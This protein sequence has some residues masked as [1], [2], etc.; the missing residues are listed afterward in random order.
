MFKT[1]SFLAYIAAAI[2]SISI[3]AAADLP[4]NKEPTGIE[5]RGILRI[6]DDFS[7]SLKKD[8]KSAWR[9][10]HQSAFGYTLTHF[11]QEDASLTL[12]D[13]NGIETTI[14]LVKDENLTLE[15]IS[16]SS[17]QTLQDEA[18]YDSIDPITLRDVHLVSAR[19]KIRYQITPRSTTQG[20]HGSASNFAGSQK[21][22]TQEASSTETTEQ[23]TSATT[24]FEL[25]ELEKVALAVYEK[26]HVPIREAPT[27]ID[28]F[29]VVTPR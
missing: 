10:L 22:G 20:N 1:P 18:G 25:T 28:V 19:D 16:D 9:T 24:T 4:D 11:S 27:D 13:F 2:I 3:A 6:G 14:K 12:M 15:V 23:N 17:T 29:H 5:L 21:I 8:S 26:H 7:F